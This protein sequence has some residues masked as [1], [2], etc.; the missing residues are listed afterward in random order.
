MLSR[1][2]KFC[3]N[4]EGRRHLTWAMTDEPGST[5]W[6]GRERHP[7]QRE[8]SGR[9]MRTQM[10]TWDVYW[11]GSPPG[12]S[13]A[14]GQWQGQTRRIRIAKSS[15]RKKKKYKIMNN[16]KWDWML[17]HL[18]TRKATIKGYCLIPFMWSSRTIEICGDRKQIRGCLRQV[19]AGTLA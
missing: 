14:W 4:P 9:G 8:Q 6:T 1:K 17:S 10:S 13:R 7:S 5:T 16:I 2:R 11:P 3:E 19:C 12:I 15:L 18:P